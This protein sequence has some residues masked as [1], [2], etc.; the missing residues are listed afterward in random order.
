MVAS[1]IEPGMR[2]GMRGWTGRS[3]EEATDKTV[4]SSPLACDHPLARRSGGNQPMG[5]KDEFFGCSFVKVHIT[6]RGLL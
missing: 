4:T 6:L 2:L 1:L 5:V 3:R